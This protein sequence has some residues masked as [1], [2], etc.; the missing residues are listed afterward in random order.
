MVKYAATAVSLLTFKHSFRATEM[1]DIECVRIVMVYVHFL[2]CF[3][4][5]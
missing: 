5:Q 2:T 4:L 3:V 1:Q